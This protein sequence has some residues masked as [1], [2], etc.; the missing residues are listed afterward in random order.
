M[1]PAAAARDKEN[2]IVP[3][4]GATARGEHKAA[5]STRRPLQARPLSNNSAAG[6][7]GG[8]EPAK[9]EPGSVPKR[10]SQVGGS[11]V[12]VALLYSRSGCC[13]GHCPPCALSQLPGLWMWPCRTLPSSHPLHS[14]VACPGS[15]TW[16]RTPARRLLLA[17]FAAGKC[18]CKC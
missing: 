12:R 14:C 16:T 7:A 2:S 9:A 4:A 8:M 1:P 3:R 17:A 10:A 5:G 6:A 18:L 11:V 15:A 13:S